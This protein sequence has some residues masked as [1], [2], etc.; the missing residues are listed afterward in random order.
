VSFGTPS[1]NVPSPVLPSAPAP[2]PAFGSP[3]Q[4]QKPQT[5]PSAGT[6]QPTYLGAQLFANP[7]NTG[8]KSLI[9]T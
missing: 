4:G 2:P 1:F 5:K 6:G 8:Q 7:S 3:T 9:G